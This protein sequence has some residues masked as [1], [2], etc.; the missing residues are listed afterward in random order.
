MD[1]HYKKTHE[2]SNAKANW[3][4][5]DQPENSDKTQFSSDIENGYYSSPDSDENSLCSFTEPL[6]HAA[7][8]SN[9]KNPRK[10][11]AGEEVD[12]IDSVEKKAE[13]PQP[14]DE[15]E[16]WCSVLAMTMRKL[17]LSAQIEMKIAISAIVG[18]KELEVLKKNGIE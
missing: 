7:V 16:S 6:P 9:L 10:R 18:K 4:I 17:P 1:E 5:V 3:V 2:G 11:R 8:N 14:L 13:N 12:A 15:L